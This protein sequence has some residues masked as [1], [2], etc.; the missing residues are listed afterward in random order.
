MIKALAI[1]KELH[2]G[3][4]NGDLRDYIYGLIQWIPD[5]YRN[6]IAREKRAILSSM[7]EI[8]WAGPCFGLLRYAMV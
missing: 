1:L 5:E 8:E 6:Q 2:A 7:E 3:L 4:I